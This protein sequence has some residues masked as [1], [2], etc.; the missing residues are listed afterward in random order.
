MSISAVVKGSIDWLNHTFDPGI[1]HWQIID[2]LHLVR[3][4][5]NT[6]ESVPEAFDCTMHRVFGD[7]LSTINLID[8]RKCGWENGDPENVGLSEQQAHGPQTDDD[9]APPP[10]RFPVVFAVE[11]EPVEHQ[12]R[13]RGHDIGVI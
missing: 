1:S 12:H 4:P 3:R 2:D 6:Q 9:R 5:C 11:K 10:Q 7:M 8:Q 13:Q